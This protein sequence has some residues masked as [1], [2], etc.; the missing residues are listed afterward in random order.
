MV[1][2]GRALAFGPRNTTIPPL[3]P[4]Y[5]ESR[6]PR[7][8]RRALVALTLAPLLGACSIERYA[9]GKVAD[10]LAATGGTYASDEDVDLIREDGSWIEPE[11]LEIENK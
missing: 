2:H 8:R 1:A 6:T 3:E 10:A 4:T 9:T 11:L 7:A 5:R